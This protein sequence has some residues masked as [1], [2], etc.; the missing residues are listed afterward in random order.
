MIGGA[1]VS[2]T[3]TRVVVAPVIAL[4]AAVVTVSL[5]LFRYG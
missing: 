3:L 4:T 5:L 1:M 2:A